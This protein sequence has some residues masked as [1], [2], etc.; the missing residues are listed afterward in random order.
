MVNSQDAKPKYDLDNQDLTGQSL[1]AAD[2]LTDAMSPNAIS[3]NAI[4]PDEMSRRLA[5]SPQAWLTSADSLSHHQAMQVA[6]AV[7]AYIGDAVYELYVRLQYLH[8]PR[9]IQTYHKQVVS[10]VRAEAQAE[11]LLTL[12]AELTEAEQDIVRRGRN[13][14]TGKPK[15]LTVEVYRHATGFEALL[16]YLYLTR[17]DRLSHLLAQINF[18]V[19]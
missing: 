5:D 18:A 2:S 10:Q 8:P 17:G 9:R 3:P 19:D 13:A 11:L 4:S 12:M 16:G 1:A 7:L 6:P 14:A 15:R